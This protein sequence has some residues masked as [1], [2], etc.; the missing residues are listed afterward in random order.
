MT[1]EQEDNLLA[2]EKH[3][4][5]P[6]APSTGSE[7][8]HIKCDPARS[9]DDSDEVVLHRLGDEVFLEIYQG[10]GLGTRHTQT[11]LSADA[12]RTLREFLNAEMSHDGPNQ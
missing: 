1:K 5:E 12:A 4:S 11:L 7:T 2:D 3:C 10:P 9:D 6:P 8:V